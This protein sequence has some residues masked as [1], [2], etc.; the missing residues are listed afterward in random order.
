MTDITEHQKI[1]ALVCMDIDT[2][3]AAAKKHP[4]K[5]MDFLDLLKAK[6]DDVV[7]TPSIRDTR[8]AATCDILTITARASE[9]KK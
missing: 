9:G 3:H 1:A 8:Y 7:D 6:K 5:A 4:D 2:I